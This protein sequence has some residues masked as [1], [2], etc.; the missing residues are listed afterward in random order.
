MKSLLLVAHGSRREPSN[1]EVRRLTQSL[2]AGG[3]RRFDFIS[4]AF[5]ELAQPSVP[6]AIDEVIDMGADEIIVVPYLLSAGRHVV[7]DIPEQIAMRKRQDGDVRIRI[8]PH[9]GAAPGVAELIINLADIEAR[10]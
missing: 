8:T 10:Q 7:K 2:L 3:I 9:L 4:C 5:L 6:E 1:S